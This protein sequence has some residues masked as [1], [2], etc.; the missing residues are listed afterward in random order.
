MLEVLL[1]KGLTTFELEWSDNNELKSVLRNETYRNVL[2][3]RVLELIP[4]DQLADMIQTNWDPDPEGQDDL[5][6]PREM[7]EA[8]AD[9][10]CLDL[11][12]GCL[13]QA[14]PVLRLR[15]L[16]KLQ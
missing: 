15:D 6:S 9:K 8:L 4:S 2:L 7:A 3:P 1:E 12:N 5:Q 10:T 14:S 13:E 16:S 11:L